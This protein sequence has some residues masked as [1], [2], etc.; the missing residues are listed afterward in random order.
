MLTIF[1][2]QDGSNKV[3]GEGSSDGFESGVIK[4]P[5]SHKCGFKK[6]SSCRLLGDAQSQTV[7]LWL[8]MVRF[9]RPK[10]YHIPPSPQFTQSRH[11][12]SVGRSRRSVTRGHHTRNPSVNC[13]ARQ[14][15]FYCFRPCCSCCG[16][17][18]HGGGNKGASL[19]TRAVCFRS[20]E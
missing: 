15:V 4:L 18:G 7:C 9:L 20:V 8:R 2:S 10:S 14:P 17:N 3:K 5:P 16:K 6:S 11:S 1:S 19:I 13:F 12:A